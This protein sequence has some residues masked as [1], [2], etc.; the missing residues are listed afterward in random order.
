MPIESIL[1]EKLNDGIVAGPLLHLTL[2]DAELPK[3][4]GKVHAVIGMR[5]AGKS[6]FLRQ[7]QSEL[8]SIMPPERAVFVIF[9]D[10]RLA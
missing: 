2:R 3:V 10:D 8:R 4:P 1:L 9:D 5:R 6:C 7:L